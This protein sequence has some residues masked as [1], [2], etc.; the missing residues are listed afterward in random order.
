MQKK[1]GK[2]LLV[3]EIGKGQF[4]HVY[5]G[6]DTENN[7]AV[8]AVKVLA[9]SKIEKSPHVY[10]LFKS[11]M[12]VMQRINHPN[13]LKLHDF[14]ETSSNFYQVVQFCP[15]GD[16]E[17][18]IQREGPI[19]EQQALFFLKQIMSGFLYLHQ[20][21]IMHRD[22]KV[23]NLFLDG[24]RIVI[25]DFGFAKAGVDVATT[26]LGTPY[27]MAPEIVFSTGRTPYTSKTDLWSIGV[28]YYQMLVG[29]LPFNA[30]TLDQLKH[31]IIHN[32]GKNLVFPNHIPISE[33]SK[34]LIRG[35]LEYDARARISWKDFFNHPVF[36]LYKDLNASSQRESISSNAMQPYTEQF[37]GQVSVP[38]SAYSGYGQGQVTA[39][40]LPHVIQNSANHIQNPNPNDQTVEEVQNHFAQEK[41]LVNQDVRFSTNIDL[42]DIVELTPH[43]D[44]HVQKFPDSIGSSLAGGNS[45][46]QNPNQM[47]NPRG[48]F[49]KS[50]I[51]QTID[52]CNNFFTHERNKYLLVFQTAKKW[53]DLLKSPKF[54]PKN[55]SVLL[56]AYSLCKRGI[57]MIDFLLRT[58]QNRV[59]IYKLPDFSDFCASTVCERLIKAFQEDRSYCSVLLNQLEQKV[60]N[61]TGMNSMDPKIL[62]N[63]QNPSQSSE[64]YLDVINE[65]LL[66]H[67]LHWSNSASYSLEE[68]QVYRH[69]LSTA[70]Y[71]HY[72]L[73]L[74]YEFPLTVDG[75]P[76]MQNLTGNAPST[77]SPIQRPF[78]W[79]A[80]FSSID[81]SSNKHLSDILSKYFSKNDE[82]DNKGC[83]LFKWDNV[84]C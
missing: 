4:G 16:L 59:D 19:Q 75:P 62:K 13:L 54:D 70:V 57:L 21:K 11:E 72:S 35:L 22:F 33:E 46:S 68:G 30:T 53:K 37:Q 25:G 2:Y 14:M 77:T 18:K 36:N 27:N 9:R 48:S 69:F 71:T 42:P 52:E 45:Y 39:Q 15:D 67:L 81:S 60:A 49:A 8:F 64:N 51:K 1:V 55:G 61:P 6:H 79:K 41:N 10:K 7:N 65:K 80:F 74:N 50:S 82:V 24:L 47:S 76:S 56:L 32:S 12:E 83:F 34:N 26:K 44:P 29:V 40:A 23:A 17:K 43:G 28:V 84:Q 38:G 66:V 78:D 20:Q 5:K 63:L 31:M 58:L 3:Q 73:N